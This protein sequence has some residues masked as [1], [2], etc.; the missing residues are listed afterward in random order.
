MYSLLLFAL[1][2]AAAAAADS[3]LAA[4]AAAASSA[5]VDRSERERLYSG[6]TRLLRKLSAQRRLV[7]EFFDKA[8]EE[9]RL[10]AVRNLDCNLPSVFPAIAQ[11]ME[12]IKI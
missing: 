5:S 8:W 1:I 2:I 10:M 7:E 12:R 4:A 3:D 6:S 11:E 9:C